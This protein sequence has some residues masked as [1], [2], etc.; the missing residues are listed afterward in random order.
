MR[1]LLLLSLVCLVLPGCQGAASTIPLAG[2]GPV[3]GVRPPSPQQLDALAEFPVPPGPT[4]S[5]SRL[6]RQTGNIFQDALPHPH[7]IADDTA[8]TAELAGDTA[9]FAYCFYRLAAGVFGAGQYITGIYPELE[10]AGG[11]PTADG[12]GLWIGFADYHSDRWRWFG[13]FT[14]QLDWLD[15]TGEVL[16]GRPGNGFLAAVN[17]SDHDLS[18]YA[19]NLRFT[20]FDIDGDEWIYY[21]HYDP[22]NPGFMPSLSRISVDGETVEPIQTGDSDL[23][24]AYPQ[25]AN[26][27]GGD[28]QVVFLMS[29]AVEDRMSYLAVDGTPPVTHLRGSASGLFPGGWDPTGMIYFWM[30]DSG[31]GVYN[32]YTEN[33]AV[34][35]F[36]RLSHDIAN[37]RDAV[38]DTS[39]FDQTYAALFT[40]LTDPPDSRAIIATIRTSD[41]LPADRIPM[42][43][44]DNGSETARDPAPYTI[45]N[46]L[47]GLN[48]GFLFASK[49]RDDST[50]NLYRYSGLTSDTTSTITPLLIDPTLDLT[51]PV[52]SP[53]ASLI[54]FIASEPGTDGGTLY[55]MD[56]VTGNLSNLTALAENVTGKLAWYDP[57]P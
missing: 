7:T 37:T 5:V 25:I 8:Y 13:P 41:A 43:V 48:Y 52:M 18:L 10:W 57:T 35:E 4:R 51:S 12:E 33:S 17:F 46:G 28:P 22:A 36:G 30:E 44:V 14:T 34:P 19:L 31:G 15:T 11:P 1:L 42:S 53:N 29:S 20:H 38:W 21:S 16:E 40:L 39:I 24:Y 47:G 54:A 56:S 45:L 26:V 3:P 23:G 27:G 55:I 9:D 2:D 6:A 32:L 49:N 50:F